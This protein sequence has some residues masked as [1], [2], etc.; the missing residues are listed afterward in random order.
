MLSVCLPL[1]IPLTDFP[2]LQ[3]PGREMRCSATPTNHTGISQNFTRQRAI[4]CWEIALLLEKRN[5]LFKICGK[6]SRSRNALT[7][8]IIVHSQCRRHRRQQ[9]CSFGFRRPPATAHDRHPGQRSGDGGG[10]RCSHARSTF[11]HFSPLVAEICNYE[12]CHG[13]PA[14]RVIRCGMDR[15]AI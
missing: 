9:L 15:A 8:I 12:M 13:Q 7:W 10:S 11:L 2:N 4:N 5:Q 3:W 14:S 1:F 6:R